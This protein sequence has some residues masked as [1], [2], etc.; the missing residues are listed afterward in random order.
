M[1]FGS[2]AY[3]CSPLGEI[4]SRLGKVEAHILGAVLLA[5]MGYVGGC[6]LRVRELGYILDP[7]HFHRV[8]GNVRRSVKT[9]LSNGLVEVLP[10]FDGEVQ[11]CCQV[12]PAAELLD[13]WLQFLDR[14]SLLLDDDLTDLMLTTP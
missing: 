6:T 13:S 2:P 1:H 11:L 4:R 5:E 7:K 3:T 9:L 8:I 14:K 12:L 10:D